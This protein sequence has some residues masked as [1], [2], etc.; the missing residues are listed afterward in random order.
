MALALDHPETVGAIVLLSGCY[1]P[2]PRADVP[3]LSGPAVPVVGDIM[4]H[5]AS[6]LI[7]RLM[8]PSLVRRMFAPAPV[9]A[10]FANFPIELSLRPS[11]IRAEAADTGLMIPGAAQLSRRYAELS[12]PVVIVAGDGDRIVDCPRQAVRLHEALPGSELRLVGGAGHMVHYTARDEVIAAIDTA[13]GC[14]AGVTGR[15]GVGE[16]DARSA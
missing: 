4:R 7:G 11:Q 2:T 3:L 12:M 6:P 10:G 8:A 14:S 5:T 13:A 15:A 1:Y 16:A 9:D